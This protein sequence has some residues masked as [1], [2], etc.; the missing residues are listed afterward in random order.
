MLISLRSRKLRRSN[1]PSTAPSPCRRKVKLSFLINRR[2]SVATF[3]VLGA[4]SLSNTFAGVVFSFFIPS[5]VVSLFVSLFFFHPFACLL[6]AEGV[7]KE[8]KKTKRAHTQTL[9]VGV[10]RSICFH[11][12]GR[13]LP[14]ALFRIKFPP[15]SKSKMGKPSLAGLEESEMAH[16]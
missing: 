15:A 16:G 3:G 11:R 1:L 8:S 2:A 5:S 14:C 10:F 13:R 6:D 9:L 12:M 7:K 4:D